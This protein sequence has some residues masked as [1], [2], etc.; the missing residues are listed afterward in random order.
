MF[1]VATP[2]PVAR[3]VILKTTPLD[4]TKPGEGKPPLNSSVPFALENVGSWD[5]NWKMEPVLETWTTCRLLVGKVTVPCPAFIG[6]VAFTTKLTVNC[7]PAGTAEVA[8]VK[9][10]EDVAWAWAAGKSAAAKKAE[11][12]MRLLT[13]SAFFAIVL[14]GRP[15]S[16]QPI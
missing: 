7:V 10:K 14:I 4:P 15:L 16:G 9:A 5:Q 8:G 2:W 6:W 11:A 1:T 3:K 12:R 13:A